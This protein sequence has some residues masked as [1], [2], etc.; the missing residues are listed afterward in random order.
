MK[1]KV[2]LKLDQI[3]NEIVQHSKLL[4]SNSENGVLSGDFGILLFLLYYAE[5]KKSVLTTQKVELYAEQAISQLIRKTNTHTYSN[6][7]SG[8]LYLLHFFRE[9]DLLDVDISEVENTLDNYLIRMLEKDVSEN[10]WDFLHGATGVA[11]YFI[12]KKSHSEHINKFIDYLYNTAKK[13][14]E[15]QF[16]KW[17][18]EILPEKQWGYNI[19]LSHGM[20]A[21]IIFFTRFLSANPQNEKIKE[22]LFGSVNYLLSQEIDFRFYGSHFPT[23]IIKSRPLSKSRIAWCYGDLGIAFALWQAGKVLKQSEWQAKALQIFKDSANRKD[24]G[25]EGVID[26]GICHGTAG[27]ALMFR[28]IYLET[29]LDIF[30][31][32]CNY[33]IEQTL[34][35]ARFPDGAVGYK[36]YTGEWI[37]DYSFLM[38]I[39]GIGLTLL[40][41]LENDSQDWDEI[42]LL[43][44]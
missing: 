11:L 7:L 37:N 33:W 34:E 25:H 29:Q 5:Y 18:S 44:Y 26:A 14:K 16:F 42:L 43:S 12:K 3:E 24:T 32:T 13:G 21:L 17:K 9:K 27:L 30:K 20:S 15:G 35:Y 36:A 1:N 8:I 10:N 38:G 31:E 6:G 28:R 23:S 39:T 41:Y 19:S 4:S 22:M 40:S 2:R